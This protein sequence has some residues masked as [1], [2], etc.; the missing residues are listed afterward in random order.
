MEDYDLEHPIH[1]EMSPFTGLSSSTFPY[2][3]RWDPNTP[4]PYEDKKIL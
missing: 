4:L 2:I 1:F 3:M